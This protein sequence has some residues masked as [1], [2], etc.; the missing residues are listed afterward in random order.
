M[1]WGNKLLLV[2][3]AFASLIGYMVYRCTNTPVN[4]VTA[5]YYKDELAYQ[6]VIDATNNANAL[7]TKA[8]L[9][10][11]GS[12]IEVQLPDE[13]KARKIKGSILFYCPYNSGNDRRIELSLDSNASQLL[14]IKKFSKGFYKVKIDWNDQHKHYYTEEPFTINAL[15]KQ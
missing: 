5:E 13:M 14:D 11:T 6:D 9:A 3:V 10:Q 7:R 2:F 12:A 8:S 4:L 15:A 1:N